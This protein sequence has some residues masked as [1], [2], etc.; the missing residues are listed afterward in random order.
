M[1]RFPSLSGLAPDK[2]QLS[3]LSGT[4]LETSD[5][6]QWTSDYLV[7]PPAMYQSEVPPVWF[8]ISISAAKPSYRCEG[9]CKHQTIKN[10]I[11]RSS[12]QAS[13]VFVKCSPSHPRTPLH[14]FSFSPWNR[15]QEA[16]VRIVC[17]ETIVSTHLSAL[18][19]LAWQEGP[20]KRFFKGS[21]FL[22]VLLLEFCWLVS[23][24]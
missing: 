5:Q 20:I 23:S 2:H 24:C 22:L 7:I 13:N 15:G 19:T 12:Y 8:L 6:S 9:R 17:K 16:H 21:F 14:I 11:H 18:H 10:L 4:S 3:S 1:Q